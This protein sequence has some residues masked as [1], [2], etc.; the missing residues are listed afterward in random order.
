ME[1]TNKTRVIRKVW[2]NAGNNQLL[3]TIP[4]KGNIKA[5]DF[6]EVIKQQIIPAQ[7]VLIE[8]KAKVKTDDKQ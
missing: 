7:N 3:I 1:Q 5:G 8:E 2:Q 4:V 6:V